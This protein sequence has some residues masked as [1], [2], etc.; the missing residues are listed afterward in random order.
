VDIA[1]FARTQ[2]SNAVY[3][4]LQHSGSLWYYHGAAILRWDW[5]EPGEIDRAVA[6]M[7]RAGHAV[8]ALLDDWEEQQ[9]RQRFTGT[10]TVAGIGAPVL[11]AGDP[12]GITARVYT[13]Q[14]GAVRDAPVGAAADR[15][16]SR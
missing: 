6:E 8:F 2:P 13:L 14:I 1:E 4:S 3:L 12:R 10:R 5:V 7:I 15:V 11:A 16:N 9:F